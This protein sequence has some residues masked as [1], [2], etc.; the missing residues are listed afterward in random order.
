MIYRSSI[1]VSVPYKSIGSEVFR[2][3]CSGVHLR[4]PR[5]MKLGIESLSSNI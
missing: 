3:I 4:E 5:E 2:G 1:R